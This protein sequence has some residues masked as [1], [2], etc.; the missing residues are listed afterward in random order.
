MRE[1]EVG[2]LFPL[3]SRILTWCSRKQDTLKVRHI[4]GW[5]NVI[6]DKLFRL[7]QTIQTEW[8]FLPGFSRQYAPGGTSLKW[9]CLPLGSTTNFHNL[10]HWYQ[11]PYL[12]NGCTHPALGGSR[13]LCLPTSC[14][15]GQS[16]G[17]VTGLPV[18]QNDF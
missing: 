14:H 17:E 8:S 1:N 4:P 16:G 11:N 10:Y 15:L 7:G 5:L 18:Q 9:T 13:T 2:P 12:G 3:L 6:A